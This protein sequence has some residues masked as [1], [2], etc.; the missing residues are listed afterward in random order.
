MAEAA[1]AGKPLTPAQKMLEHFRAV[2][3]ALKGMFDDMRKAGHLNASEGFVEFLDK[4][5]KGE[6]SEERRVG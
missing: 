1:A 4:A 3:K 6:R 2:I 5:A